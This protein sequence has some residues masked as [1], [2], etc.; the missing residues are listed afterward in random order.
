MMQRFSKT[1]LALALAAGLMLPVLAPAGP[2]L[3]HEEPCP[4][5][6]AVLSI[7]GPPHPADRNANNR[8]CSKVVGAQHIVIDDHVHHE[9][10]PK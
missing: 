4:P 1:T 5:G 9:P 6:F 10:D 3:A 8:V 7:L 2:A